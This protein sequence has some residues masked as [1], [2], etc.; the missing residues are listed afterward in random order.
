MDENKEDIT[1]IRK[2]IFSWKTGI[3][4]VICIVLIYLA[5]MPL[6]ITP[7]FESEAIVYV[8]LT[9]P[10]QQINQQGIGFAGDH[11]VDAYIQILRSNA[12]A[13]SLIQH[14]GL[15]KRAGINMADLYASLES[16]IKIDKTRYSSVSIKVRDRSPETASAMAND[17]I[18]LGE[19]IKCTLFLPNRREAMLYSK[20]LY[21]EK[22][23]EVI[24]LEKTLDSLER[25]T[26]PELLKRDFKYEKILTTY[27][28]ELQEMV[29]RKNQYEH[30][31]KDFE[32]PLPKAYIIS[33]AVPMDH[34]VWPKRGLMCVLGA[35]AYLFIVLITEIIKRDVRKKPA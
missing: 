26:P 19:S 16:H 34:P 9:I 29:S 4:L 6:L 35:F 27:R 5:T 20:S 14:F 13:D 30:A 33:Q 7:L 28:L 23:A 10:N 21:D 25:K 11:E 32:T 24:S 2:A 3:G 1:W 8:P 17:I 15:N 18:A 22:A 12:L 31:N